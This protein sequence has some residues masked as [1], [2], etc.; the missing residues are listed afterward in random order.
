MQAPEGGSDEATNPKESPN[1]ADAGTPKSSR[2]AR[3]SILKHDHDQEIQTPPREVRELEIKT[4]TQH[5]VETAEAKKKL[6]R[7]KDS[8]AIH[9]NHLHADEQRGCFS[10]FRK[11][12]SDD[13]HAA[14]AAGVSNA[15]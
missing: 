10:C 12:P 11:K 6:M 2:E 4:V 13:E 1:S 15:V 5:S 14:K 7:R 8:L 9:K 3:H